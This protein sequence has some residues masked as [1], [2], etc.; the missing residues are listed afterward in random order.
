MSDPSNTASSSPQRAG[1]VTL[2]GAT[3]AGKS[4]LLN[5][6]V[7]EKIAIISH[8]VQTTRALVR[9]IT[10]HNRAQMIFVDTPGIFKPKR[11][12]DKAMIRAAWNGLGEGDICCLIVDC[13]R[14]LSDDLRQMLDHLKDIPV[15][16]ILVLNKI[17]LIAREKLLLLVQ[18]IHARLSFQE[19]FMVSALTGDGCRALLDSLA[20]AMPEGPWLYPEGQMHDVPLQFLAAEI[21]RE[22][23]YARLH[24]ELPYAS[25]VETESWEEFDNGS[26]K[27]RQVI[28]VER[29]SQ[30][31]IV[32][33]KNGEAIKWISQKSRQELT[34]LFGRTVHLFLFVKVREKWS[35]K[36]ENL[37]IWGSES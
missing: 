34:Q 1:F 8:K 4:T 29:E 28:L 20:K 27:I 19:T 33:G 26:V 31:K 37:S 16:R 32:L 6:L 35:Q 21:T 30:K 18:D 36:P 22:K 14:G 25:M 3:N 17:D 13:A 11:A 5:R 12:L 10:I 15:P 2:F 23:L 7:G 24:Q 9:G